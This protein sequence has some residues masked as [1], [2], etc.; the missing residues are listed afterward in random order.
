MNLP[1]KEELAGQ[2]KVIGDGR[3][4]INRGH[5]AGRDSKDIAVFLMWLESLEKN[6][7]EQ[8]TAPTP[9]HMPAVQQSPSFKEEVAAL[10]Q[11]A[12]A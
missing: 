6:A 11:V 5:F 4:A 3:R 9:V 12:N 10:P 1:T 7:K 8:L 2:L